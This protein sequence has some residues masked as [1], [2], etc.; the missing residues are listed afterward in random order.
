MA[1]SWQAKPV[2]SAPAKEFLL[3]YNK[4]K[5]IHGLVEPSEDIYDRLLKTGLFFSSLAL[6]TL[7]FLFS[8]ALLTLCG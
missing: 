8:S 3:V 2:A 7:L 1:F 4:D 5:S 6:L